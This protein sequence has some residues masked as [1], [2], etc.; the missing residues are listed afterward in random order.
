MYF[1]KILVKFTY[2]DWGKSYIDCNLE[3]CEYFTIC[4][5]FLTCV[6]FVVSP[7]KFNNKI[8]NILHLLLVILSYTTAATIIQ[9]PGAAIHCEVIALI[10]LQSV[11]ALVHDVLARHICIIECLSS[12]K[13]KW[14]RWTGIQ[15]KKWN[16][17]MSLQALLSCWCSS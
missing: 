17:N 6:T 16:K 3:R 2:V 9:Q 11:I 4:I 13:C 7:Q 5:L 8:F 14:W 12:N 1:L 15:E 10:L